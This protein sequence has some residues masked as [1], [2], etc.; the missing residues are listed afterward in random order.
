M[1]SF[2]KKYFIQEL[3]GAKVEKSFRLFQ[4]YERSFLGA[5]KNFLLMHYSKATLMEFISFKLP[6]N[7]RIN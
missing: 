7:K 3:L 6:A 5:L 2:M 1:E 4:P